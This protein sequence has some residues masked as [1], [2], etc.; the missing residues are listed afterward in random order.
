MCPLKEPPLV[1]TSLDKVKAIRERPEPKIIINARS[2]HDLPSFY[3]RFIRH[4]SSI[5]ALITDSLKKGSLQW[6]SKVASAFMDLKD[7]MASAP[8]LRHPD[9]NKVFKVACDA[10][11]MA[12]AAS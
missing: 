2:F 10:S 11:G 9:F 12:L 6:T 7:R 4:F 8:V 1:S 3:K 5:I